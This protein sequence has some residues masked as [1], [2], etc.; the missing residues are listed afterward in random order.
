MDSIRCCGYA[1]L[2]ALLL[3]AC[4]GTQTTDNKRPP[5]VDAATS[6]VADAGVS[7]GA[8]DAGSTAR[9]TPSKAECNKLVDHVLHIAVIAHNKKEDPKYRPTK[10]Q[11]EQIRT[12][13][14]AELGPVCQRFRRDMYRCV[15]NATDRASYAACGKGGGTGS[16]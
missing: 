9:A 6:P 3:T 2:T 15:M 5:A 7:A 10:Q 12:K 4:G 1:A 14:R 13:F 16:P 8:K 11:I